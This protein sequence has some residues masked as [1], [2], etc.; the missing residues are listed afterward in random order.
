M[1]TL[2]L[3]NPPKR[4]VQHWLISIGLLVVLTVAA[5]LPALRNGFIWD[6]DDNVTNNLPLRNL[7]GLQ[8]IW[9]EPGAT[10]QYYPLTHTSFWLEY[11][12]WGLNPTGYHTTNVL[13]HAFN[14]ALLWLIL[15][16]LNVKGAGLAA[17]IF[18]LHPVCVESVAWITERKNTL[19]G[20]FYLGAVLAYL[21]CVLEQE[22]KT[23]HSRHYWLALALYLCALW[24]KTSTVPLP[25]VLLLLVWWQR[26]KLNWGTILPMAPFLIV[27]VVMGLVTMWV[28]KNHVGMQGAAWEFSLAERCVIAGRVFWFYLCK[29][30]W[31]HPLIFV[32]PRWTI[33]AGRLVSYL[34]VLM[35]MAGLFV[36]W[37][38][39][40]GWARSTFVAM[41]YFLALL[42]PVLGFFNV[43]YF[44][45][46]FVCDHFQYLAC[47]GPLALG[48]AG[49]TAALD[50]FGGKSLV[51]KP[52]FCGA[53]LLTLGTLTWQQSGIYRSDETLWRDVLAKN[54]RAWMVHN[55][56]GQLL[57]RR[58]DVAEAEAHFHAALAIRPD[59]LEALNNLGLL[60]ADQKQ[61]TEAIACYQTALRLRPDQADI[62]VNLGNAFMAL[63]NTDDAIRQYR[64][65][66]RFAPD[67]PEA[68]NNLGRAL[69]M[70]GELDEAIFHFSEA[71][72][73]NPDFAGAHFNLG[74]AYALQGRRQEAIAQFREA[75][76]LEP[77]LVEAQRQL[78][79]LG[80]PFSQ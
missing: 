23:F 37:R 31:P 68:H 70:R 55:N 56:L 36:L 78:R 69:A 27:G 74:N 60:L 67:S 71:V 15:R 2:S 14:A 49:F 4:P 75:L 64:E 13:L 11:H 48:A 3:M 19:S 51:L 12:L 39:R 28:E 43:F 63:D 25:A 45:Y 30:V 80:A 65:S 33:E 54:P 7:N 57:E 72:R 9:L 10:Q 17:A 61:Y 59:Y 1:S 44:C 34:P 46:S 40:N 58:G 77:D 50:F 66:L 21:K 16:R 32:Y 8:R 24:S 26:G 5:Y 73:A 6:D 53:L 62:H 47:I 35:A 76:R 79:A 41:M 18:A 29:L 52:A 38:N 42:F 20:M 22:K